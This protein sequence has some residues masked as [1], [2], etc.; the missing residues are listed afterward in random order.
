MFLTSFTNWHRSKQ[1]G[2]D[3]YPGLLFCLQLFL[4]CC[5]NCFGRLFGSDG[6][7][8][9][10]LGCGLIA[11]EARAAQLAARFAR[12]LLADEIELGAADAG[13]LHDLYLVYHRRIQREYLF[14]PDSARY[15]AHGKRASRFGTVFTGEDE[16]LECLKAGLAL[17]LYLLEYAHGVPRAKVEVLAGFHVYR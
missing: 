7:F 9:G 5:R 3:I 1:K 11:H 16:A 13:A 12:D 2:P 15:A 17:F 10:L 8:F 14:D 4:G 6:R